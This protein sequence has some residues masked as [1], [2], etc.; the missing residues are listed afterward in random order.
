MTT[1]PLLN[2]TLA[3]FLSPELGFF[4]FVIPVFRHTPF[5]SGRLC[6]AGD[7]RLRA[8][9]STRHPRRTWL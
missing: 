4:G 2:R 6:S 3:V 1:L 8:G 7:R 9:C 5:I